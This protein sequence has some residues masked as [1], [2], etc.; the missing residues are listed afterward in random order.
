MK[1]LSVLIFFLSVNLSAEETLQK[2]DLGKLLTLPSGTKLTLESF[3]KHDPECAVPGFNCGISYNP[4]PYIQPIIKVELATICQKYPLPKVCEETYKIKSTDNKN[5]VTIQVVNV[6][7]QCEEDTNLDN[8]YSCIIRKARNAFD[9]PAFRHQNCERIRESQE[10]R[11]A[12]YEA[13]AGKERDVKICDLVKG[14][15]TFECIYLRAITKKDPEVCKT[16]KMNKYH[17][18]KQSHL[19][20]IDA[21][22]NSPLVKGNGKP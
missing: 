8:R 7:E 17:H 19:D 13:I 2:I 6:F 4:N 22:A 9:R 14:Q 12:C 18:S 10:L 21:C 3:K 11:D 5:Y 20:Q 16:L 1:L 15:E